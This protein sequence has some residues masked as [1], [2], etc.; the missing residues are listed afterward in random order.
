MLLWYL[1]NFF[2]LKFNFMLQKDLK[3]SFL[4]TLK[5]IHKT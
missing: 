3:P 4:K 1:D 2:K 5:E